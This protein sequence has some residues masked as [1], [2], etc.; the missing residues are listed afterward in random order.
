MNEWKERDP[1]V[2]VE[3]WWMV[4]GPLEVYAAALKQIDPEAARDQ[5]PVLVEA[6]EDQEISICH[7][8]AWYA[9]KKIDSE[10]AA[11]SRFALVFM[12]E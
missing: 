3:W 8:D 6:L 11:K 4:P 7:L 12:D 2:D 5:V 9:F 1:K 10:A